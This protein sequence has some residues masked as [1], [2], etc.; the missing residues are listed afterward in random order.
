M[1]Q[2][3]IIINIPVKTSNMLVFC[4]AVKKRMK[5]HLEE[6]IDLKYT[7]HFAFGQLEAPYQL[8][9]ESSDSLDYIFEP[10]TIKKINS[11]KKILYSIHF[12]DIAVRHE[13]SNLQVELSAGA[14]DKSVYLSVLEFV[15]HIVDRISSL[16]LSKGAKEKAI[17]SRELFK[18]SK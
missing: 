3:K 15:F 2:D 9:G 5:K 10:H 6:N 12:T 18:E 1:D 11:F 14:E 16:K 7:K 13:G 8:Y 17:K 4:L